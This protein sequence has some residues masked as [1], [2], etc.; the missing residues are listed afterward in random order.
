M[1]YYSANHYSIVM[2][3]EVHS[4][5]VGTK[6]YNLLRKLNHSGHNT[7]ASAVLA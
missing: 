3:S 6:I 5:T 7:Y 4:R 2:L 1:M